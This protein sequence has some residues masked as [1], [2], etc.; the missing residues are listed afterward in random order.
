MAKEAGMCVFPPRDHVEPSTADPL[1]RVRR[2][3][4]GASSPER[5][6]TALVLSLITVM[7]IASLGAGLVQLHTAIDRRHE[8]AIDRKRA[9]Y[10]AEAGLG[11]AAL[12]VS[13]GRSGAIASEAVPATYG[14]GV[15]WV[16]SDDLP[17]DRVVL[18]CTA[19]I[20]TAEFVVRTMIVPNVNPVTRLGL[21]GTDGVHIGWGSVIDGYH[22][23]RGNFASQVDATLPVTS[24]GALGLVGSDA[25]IVLSE[26]RALAGADAVSVETAADASGGWG[27]MVTAG[28]GA[29][30]G[31]G[32]GTGGTGGGTGG[33]ASPDP[34]TP[35]HIYGQ[36]RP[37]T[38]SAVR[39][40]GNSVI[41]G[42]VDPFDAPPV[43]PEITIP[44]PSEVLNLDLV[45]SSDQ[46][47][48]G[49]NVQTWVQGDI[50]VTTGSTL[51]I[52]GP[53]VLRCG[54]LRVQSRAR[55]VLDDGAGPVHVYATE[56]LNLVR[57]SELLTPA[58]EE[59]S[60]GTYLFVPGSAAERDRVNLRCSGSFHGA[61]Y[62]P[63]DVIL[64]PET[65]RWLGSAVGR[66]VA[67]APGSHLTVD[68]RLLIR[69]ARV[70]AVPRQLTG[71]VVPQG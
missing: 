62:A 59:D 26:V 40:D 29:T 32:G 54:A 53:A 28:G 25:D 64:I 2:A 35:T 23:G 8:F 21:F 19:R 55:L 1:P 51:T 52:V 27:G 45:I 61:I 34:S 57:D 70:P 30:G 17:D 20:S 41:V 18:R 49:S 67:T 13:Q 12:A 5:R 48:I 38:S 63:D 36:L 33:T 24:T 6:G 14:G 66:V 47:N 68:R 44:T 15:Y 46:T 69:G 4:I 37:G 10:L 43:L 65:L 22:S 42:T 9:L 58:D 60:R 11:E 56:G 16:E 7:I 3:A 50:T 39:S 71:Q 31:S